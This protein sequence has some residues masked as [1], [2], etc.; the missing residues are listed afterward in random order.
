MSNLLANDARNY[1]IFRYSSN[2]YTYGE[3]LSDYDELGD[4]FGSTLGNRSAVKL[5]CHGVEQVSPLSHFFS[6]FMA[7]L[8]LSCTILK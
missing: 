2:N 7:R 5:S 1:L 3:M 6:G 4:D 8:K